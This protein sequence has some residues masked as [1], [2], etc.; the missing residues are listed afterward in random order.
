ML[1]KAQREL[2]E[3]IEILTAE[4]LK[5]LVVLTYTD[6]INQQPDFRLSIFQLMN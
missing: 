6:F 5:V 3:C 1:L 2:L 4:I